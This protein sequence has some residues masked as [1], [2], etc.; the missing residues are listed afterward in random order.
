MFLKYLEL[1]NFRNYSNVN[2]DL[3]SGLILFL[4]NNGAG[5]TNLLESVF[6][7]SNGKSHRLSTQNDLINWKSDYCIIRGI[8]ES[9]GEDKLIEIQLNNDGS[10]KIKLNKVFIKNKSGFTSDLATVIFSPDDLRIIKS[11]PFYRRNFLDDILEKTDRNFLSLRLKYQR[12]LNQRNSLLKSISGFNISSSNNTIEVWNEKLVEMGSL[13]INKRLNLLNLIKTKFIK[14]MN[15]FF[16]S[17]KADVRYIFSW[18]RFEPNGNFTNGNLEN[19]TNISDN[20]PARKKDFEYNA[21]SHFVLSD[22]NDNA[23]F[24]ETD[25]ISKKSGA[26]F[27]SD[28]DCLNNYSLNNILLGKVFEEKLNFYFKKDVA[29]KTTTVGPHRD[30]LVITLGDDCDIRNFGSQG[31]Q[32]IAAICLKLAEL[33]LLAENINEK[34]MLLLDDVLSELD[35]ERKHLLLQLIGNNYQTFITA[36]NFDYLKD[37]DLKYCEKYLVKDNEIKRY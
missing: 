17:R 11:S 6:Y 33:D 21:S 9:G 19:D 5:K 1:K 36:A 26:Y 32:R 2:L 25:T 15:Y 31:Q 28:K 18:D 22:L 4:G 16:E 30:D 20:Q 13:I 14:Y 3:N 37:I 7:L 27:V 8:I 23:V 29:I 34:P 35:L 24:I 12:I 10:L